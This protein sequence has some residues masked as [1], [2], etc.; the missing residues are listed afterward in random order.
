MRVGTITEIS[1]SK[2][3]ANQIIVTH[4][5]GSFTGYTHVGKASGI[6]KGSRVLAGQHI[7]N[8]DGSGTSAAHLHLS[9]SPNGVRR[10]SSDNR[11]NPMNL[12]N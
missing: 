6:S 7:G 2:G 8:S 5:D 11:A 10:Y 9:Y 1:R 3:G 12:F 4:P